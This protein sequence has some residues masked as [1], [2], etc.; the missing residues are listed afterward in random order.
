MLAL[1]G[2]GG[3]KRTS[4]AS[5]EFTGPAA[6]RS[7]ICARARRAGSSSRGRCSTAPMATTSPNLRA[8]PLTRGLEGQIWNVADD[9]P[10]PPAERGRLCDGAPRPA[11]AAR[12]AIRRSAALVDDGRVLRRQQ[13]G[14]DRQGQDDTGVCPRLSNLSRGARVSVLIKRFLASKGD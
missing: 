12:G 8:L 11:G 5:P 13:A 7:S 4:C 9:E 1:S 6:T 3:S 2:R 10:V 14:F